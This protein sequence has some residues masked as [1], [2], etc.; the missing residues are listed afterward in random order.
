MMLSSKQPLALSKNPP[1]PDILP[2]GRREG[3]KR[4]QTALKDLETALGARK[5]VD[6]VL[7]EF[8]DKTDP[9]AR[10]LGD[11]RSQCRK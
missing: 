2:E 5:P 6:I 11:P 3:L 1:S 7:K 8:L 10:V 4:L 9:A